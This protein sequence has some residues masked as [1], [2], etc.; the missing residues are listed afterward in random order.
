MS[1]RE[2]TGAA[3]TALAAVLSTSAKA[4]RPL[5]E[6]YPDKAIA[7][8]VDGNERGFEFPCLSFEKTQELTPNLAKLNRKQAEEHA[9]HLLERPTQSSTPGAVIQANFATAFGSLVECRL[10]AH[11][12]RLGPSRD[13]LLSLGRST[14]SKFSVTRIE[15]CSERNSHH[16]SVCFVAAL[17][18]A[19]PESSGSER[20]LSVAMST[21]GSIK[22]EFDCPCDS[23]LGEY[24]HVFHEH[25]L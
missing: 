8:P 2:D 25:S 23:L 12:Q 22:G 6:P 20:L 3:L 24:S 11:R 14:K 1:F 18:I 15:V 16:A 21:A 10:R 17:D 5:L 13:L 19:I 7:A 9:I 4:Q